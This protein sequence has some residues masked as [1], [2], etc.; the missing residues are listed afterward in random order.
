MEWADF[1]PEMKCRE[2][3]TYQQKLP[4]PESNKIWHIERHLESCSRYKNNLKLIDK[5]N[6]NA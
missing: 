5:A 3:G 1:S 4:D 2:C 6:G